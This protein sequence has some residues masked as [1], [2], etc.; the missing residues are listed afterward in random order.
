MSLPDLKA[1]KT[2]HFPS[3]K[4][5][6]GEIEETSFRTGKI[7]AASFSCSSIQGSIESSF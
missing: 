2:L 4:A 5:A 6:H 1:P 7:N 3:G